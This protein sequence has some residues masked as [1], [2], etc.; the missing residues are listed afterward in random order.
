MQAEKLPDWMRVAQCRKCDKKVSLRIA[1][2]C[3]VCWLEEKGSQFEWVKCPS[4]DIE[5]SKLKESG[6]CWDCDE[7]K[8]E[9]SEKKAWINRRIKSIFGSKEAIQ[10]YTLENFD[11]I[12]GTESAW[13]ASS[14]FEPKTDNLYLWGACG[15][16]KTHLAYAVGLKYLLAGKKVENVSVR[17]LFNRFRMRK[18]DEESAEMAELTSADVLIVDDLGVSKATDFSLELLCE[19]INKRTLKLKNGLIVTSNL[20]LDELARKNQDD[21][22]SS[23]LSGMCQVI[24]IFSNVDYR[25]ESKRT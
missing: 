16:G 6:I 2:K 3:V 1:G 4:C 20:S 25:A 24:E 17:E 11:R 7:K 9:E 8:R 23:R 21:R 12:P 10:W 14:R 13:E 5:W 19:I 22:L 15:R 18:P